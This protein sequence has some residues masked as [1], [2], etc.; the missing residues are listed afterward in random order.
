VTIKGKLMKIYQRPR[1]VEKGKRERKSSG[2]KDT[3]KE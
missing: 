3:N 2:G 1:I